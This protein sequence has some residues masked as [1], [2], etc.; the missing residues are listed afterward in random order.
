MGS[1]LVEG[2]Y[3]HVWPSALQ[4]PKYLTPLSKI[5]SNHSYFKVGKD[6]QTEEPV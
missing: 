5:D 3:I 1:F 4:A 6:T 2:L